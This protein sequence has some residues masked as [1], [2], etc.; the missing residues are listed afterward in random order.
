MFGGDDLFGDLP[1]VK[2]D[3]KQSKT[4]DVKCKD[5]NEKQKTNKGKSEEESL[6]VSALGSAGTTMAF[7]PAALQRRKRQQTSLSPM[8]RVKQIQQQSKQ[9]QSKV[10]RHDNNDSERT[11]SNSNLKTSTKKTSSSIHFHDDNPSEEK[12]EETKEAQKLAERNQSYYEES[13]EILALH[14]HVSTVLQ[15]QEP[16]LIYDPHV[17]NDYL[18]FKQDESQKAYRAEV[19]ASAREAMEVQRIMQEQVERERA[20]IERGGNLDQIVASRNSGR[21]RGRGRGISNLPAWLVKKQEQQQQQQKGPT[22]LN[23]RINK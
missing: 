8:K 11:D 1:S 10:S 19:E 13:P 6:L 5:N 9:Q 17:P 4:D 15:V 7:V 3:N 20:A 23:D 2:N 16:H 21:G 14:T 22:L 18:Q 12:I